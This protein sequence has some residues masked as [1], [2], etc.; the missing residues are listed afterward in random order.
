MKR[1]NRI[2]AL[3]IILA[4]SVCG[5]SG[6]TIY[7][8]SIE[9]ISKIKSQTINGARVNKGEAPLPVVKIL[10][11]SFYGDDFDN[12]STRIIEEAVKVK[13]DIYSAPWGED[14]RTKQNVMITSNDIPDIMVIDNNG[15]EIK[16]AASGE[17]LPLNQYFSQYPNIQKSRSQEI[18]DL[19]KFND[20]NIYSI[21]T[22]SYFEGEPIQISRMLL[23]RE[24]WLMKFNQKIPETLEEY[25]KAAKAVSQKDPDGDGKKNTYA[26]SGNKDMVIS[27]TFDH[28]FGAFGIQANFWF[29]KDGKIVNGSIMPEAKEAL[30]FINK[31]YR[32]GMID[33]E[34]ITDD[35][36]RQKNKFLEG[37]YSGSVFFPSVMDKYANTDDL[38]R[39]FKKSN[40]QGA[41]IPGKPLSNPGYKTMGPR[42]LTARGWI[43]TVV[44]A[45]S[46]VIDSVL[47]VLDFSSSEE[48]IMLYNFGIKDTNYVERNGKIIPFAND[49]E[50]K[51]VGINPY[52]I[53]IIRTEV[54]PSTAREYSQKIMDWNKSTVANISDELLIP[55]IAEYENYLNTFTDDQ[56]SKMIMG[57]I[58]I[59][60]GFEQF[61]KEWK[62]RGGERAL[63][64]LNKA[65]NK[66]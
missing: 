19:M 12:E 18:W 30:K 23:Y 47:R 46:K 58:P 62:A 54:L 11:G 20:G 24:D 64:A 42:G 13:L 6:Y 44:M 59:D 37:M 3:F 33:P 45:K 39:V 27:N 35:Q 14:F 40:P 22:Y 7:Q 48:G 21:P 28:I 17:L 9:N 8:D 25:Y 1:Y 26:I 56:F 49:E 57:V 10:T 50:K 4:V 36:D 5:C 41:F 29:V 63:Y 52:H 55:E 60:E 53:P 34:F 61:V 16:Y 31:M 66:K 15:T 51:E 43:R 2:M 38:Y 65:Y 32:E